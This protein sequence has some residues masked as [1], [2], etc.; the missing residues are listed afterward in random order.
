MDIRANRLKLLPAGRENLET[1]TC[2]D[3]IEMKNTT[4]LGSYGGDAFSWIR[5]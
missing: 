1:L 2:L 4:G 3:L 5:T